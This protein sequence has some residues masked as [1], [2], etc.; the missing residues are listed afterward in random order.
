MAPTRLHRKLDPGRFP[1]MR[2]QLAGVLGFILER[3][4]TTPSLADTKVTPDGHVLAWPS[5]SDGIGHSVHLGP[6]TGLRAVPCVAWA[7][8][9][10][11]TR[12]R[13]HGVYPTLAPSVVIRC[14]SVVVIGIGQAFWIE[15]HQRRKSLANFF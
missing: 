6:A 13:G 4:Y 14:R 8:P 5:E 12:P 2:V 11:S 10:G 3:E 15:R 1:N 7:C 9:P